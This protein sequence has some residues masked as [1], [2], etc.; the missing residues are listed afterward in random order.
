M[1]SNVARLQCKAAHKHFEQ[2]YNSL[3]HTHTKV[4]KLTDKSS[5]LENGDDGLVDNVLAVQT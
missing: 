3:P 5:H 2:S 1:V 4:R